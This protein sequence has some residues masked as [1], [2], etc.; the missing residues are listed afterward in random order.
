[1][2]IR[3]MQ[4]TFGHLDNQRLELQPGLNVISGSNE[5]GKSTWAEFLMAMLYGVDTKV[6]ARGQELP[7]KTKYAPWSGKPMAGKMEVERQGRRLIL[8]RTSETGPMTGFTARDSETGCPAEGLT[9]RHCG[10]ALTG[11]EAGV[12]QRSAFLRQR[13]PA[14]TADPMLEKRLSSLVTTGAEDYA[15]GEI[16]EKLRRLQTALWYNQ[17]GALPKARAALNEK[18]TALTRFSELQKKRND[19]YGE[20][21]NEQTTQAELNRAMNALDLLQQRKLYGAVE[22]ARAALSEAERDCA[23]WEELCKTLPDPKALSSMKAEI[24][25]LRAEAEEAAEEARRNPITLPELPE[26]LRFTGLSGQQ[27]RE[28]TQS[29][30]AE[31]RKSLELPSKASMTFRLIKWLL[32]ALLCFGLFAVLFLGLVSF[33]YSDIAAWVLLG[34]GCAWTIF[35]VIRHCRIEGKNRRIKA[36]ADALLTFYGAGTA[37]EIVQQGAEYVRRMDAARAARE[38][39]KHAI[40]RRDEQARNIAERQEAFLRAL[41]HR[42]AGCDSLDRAEMWIADAE[43]SMQR[44]DQ[45]RQNVRLRA[46]ELEQLSRTVPTPPDLTTDLSAYEG[47]EPTEIRAGL[48]QCGKRLSALRSE[49]D[50]LSGAI[51]QKGDPLVLNAEKEA[52]EKEILRLETRYAALELAR[53]ALQQADTEVRSRFAPLLCKRAGALF[54]ALTEG[55]Y[56]HIQLDRDLHV[57]VHPVNSTVNRS[58][59]YLSGGTADQLYLALRLAICDLLL[60]EAPI[61]LDDALVF[62]DD[63]RTKLAL[64]VLK[65]LGRQ[66]QIL[67]F[68]CQRREKALLDE[69]AAEQRNA[70]KTE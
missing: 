56:D 40:N 65:Q 32:P 45:S 67:L 9:A 62:F 13:R 20:I 51:G 37:Y 43:Q 8:E 28:K 48:S 61:V 29:D 39:A 52:L 12:Y 55:K 21:Q 10:V 66:R 44:L 14:V 50:R 11:V 3:S 23:E 30:A 4:A 19:L 18:E 34:L 17:T 31:V 33:P 53:T 7:V 57:T 49:A 60:P 68:T 42:G 35:S 5:A 22:G 36:R 16:D 25:A 1:M 24:R 58:L 46:Q 26:D 64:K 41:N 63:E 47:L 6:R 38:Q 69:L 59:S 27:V 15:Y 70:A 54:Y 2:I